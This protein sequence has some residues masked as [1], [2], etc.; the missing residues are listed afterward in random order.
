MNVTFK[1][2]GSC[3][4][5]LYGRKSVR[6]RRL[7]ARSRACYLGSPRTSPA[8][9]WL[10]SACAELRHLLCRWLKFRS[11]RNARHFSVSYL[12][13]VKRAAALTPLC[14]NR[15]PCSLS[16]EERQEVVSICDDAMVRL[17]TY[18][19]TFVAL[20]P[21][22]GAE[23]LLVSF[24]KNLP[25]HLAVLRKRYGE[26]MAAKSVNESTTEGPPLPIVHE[27]K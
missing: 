15:D 18:K 27:L 22:R 20:L 11:I 2:M 14:F 1:K 23:G 6:A 19:Q 9:G 8:L 4:A 10:L 25:S 17:E 5:L 13:A 26:T 21:D 12:Q 16:E 24:C 7:L 3:F